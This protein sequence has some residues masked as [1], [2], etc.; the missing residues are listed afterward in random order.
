MDHISEDG[1][2]AYSGGHLVDPKDAR[3]LMHLLVCEQCCRLAKLHDEYDR[4]TQEAL[5]EQKEGEPY[6]RALKTNGPDPPDLP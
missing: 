3:T 4:I 2:F 1:L 5:R 6:G